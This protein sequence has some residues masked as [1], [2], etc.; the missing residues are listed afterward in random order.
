MVF[1]EYIRDLRIKRGVSQTEL[2]KIMGFKNAQFISNWERGLAGVPVK[3]IFTLA[4][5]FDLSWETLM[6]AYLEDMRR[7]IIE[8]SKQ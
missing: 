4:K 8:R 3:H 2:A 7:Q 6:R 5:A 1:G